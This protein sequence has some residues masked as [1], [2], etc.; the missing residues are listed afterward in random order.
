MLYHYTSI[1]AFKSILKNAKTQMQMCFWAT[2]YDCF[3]DKEEF[4][5]GIETIK[6]LLPQVEKDLPLDRQIASSFEWDKIEGNTN[7]PFPYIISF[8][9]RPDNSYMWE[10]YAKSNGIVMEIDD[11]QNFH[12]Q[13]VTMTRLVSCIYVDEHIDDKLVNILRDEYSSLGYALLKEPNKDTAFYLLKNHPQSF[14]ALIAM[15]LLS[16]VAPRIKRAK[17]YWMEEETRTIIPIPIPTYSKKI[18]RFDEIIAKLGISPT[19]IRKIVSNEYSRKRDD[20][21]TLYYRKLLLP[22]NL[23]KGIYVKSNKTKE[24]VETFLNEQNT[25]IPIIQVD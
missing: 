10:E 13:E 7:L 24:C 4:K 5:L 15:G 19:W 14:V 2:R 21:S 20:G 8:T 6:R 11:N 17:D 18:E 16:F 1:D 3:A 12:T 23:L 25:K 9:S 22:I